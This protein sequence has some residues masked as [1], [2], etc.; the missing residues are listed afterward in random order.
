MKRYGKLIFFHIVVFFLVVALTVW[1]DSRAEAGSAVSVRMESPTLPVVFAQSGDLAVNPLRGYVQEMRQ[2]FVH[3]PVTP[4]SEDLSLLFQ[5]R[6]A[7][8]VKGA[9]YRIWSEDMS[10][11]VEEGTAQKEEDAEGLRLLC[12][13]QNLYQTGSTYRMALTLDLGEKSAV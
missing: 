7:G 13:L 9:S 11:L 4:L 2:A 1:A 10:R 8:G 6:A 12:C 5:V 3:A